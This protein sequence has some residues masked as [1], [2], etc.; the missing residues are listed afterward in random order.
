M[1]YKTF[2]ITALMVLLLSACSGQWNNPH[3]KEADGL[4]VYYTNFQ[5]SPQHL[6]PVVSYSSD[7]NLFIAQIYEPPLGYHFLKRP[8]VLEPLVAQT[9]PEIRFLDKNFRPVKKES[10]DVRY[11]EYTIR[12][13]Q[14]I[15]YQPHP[16]FVMRNGQYRYFFNEEE[17]GKYYRTV[18]DFD[19]VA[20]RELNADDFIYQIKRMADPAVHSPMMGFMSKYIVGMG[21]MTEQL[22]TADREGWLDLRDFTMKGLNKIDEYTYSITINGIYPQFS[23]WLAMAFFAPVPWEADRFFNNPGF[24]EKNLTLDWYPVGTGPFM[25]TENDPN[26]AIILERNPNY[27]LDLYPSEG[28]QEDVA[29][30]YLKDAGK[31]VPFIDKAIFSLDKSTLPMWTKFLQGYYDRSGENHGNVTQNFDQALAIGP[32]GIE[33]SSEMQE[34]AITLS[35]DIKPAIYFYGFNMQ[36]PVVGG[37]SEKQ[38]KLRQAIAIVWDMEAFIDIFINGSALAYTGP[39]APGINGY[40]EGKQGIN[41]YT[42]DWVNG[43]PL[44]KSIAYAQQLMKEAGYPGGRDEK[45]GKPLKLYFDVQSQASGRTSQEWQKRQLKKLGIELEYRSSD[46]NRYK[47]KLRDGNFQL[48]TSGWL[49]DYPD[50][51]NFLFLLIGEEAPLLGNPN[52]ANAANY[53]NPEYNRLF[54]QM[55]TMDNSPERDRIIEKMVDIVRRDSPWFTGY[56]PRE[57]FLNN[58]WVYNGKRHGIS[59]GTLKYLRIDDSLRHQKQAEW[60]RPIVLPLVIIMLVFLMFC[61]PAI[62]AYRRRQKMTINMKN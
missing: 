18:A 24:K 49:A 36:D 42:H 37:Y 22:R 47:E 56:Y 17:E 31:S 32:N 1:N 2:G 44:R 11:S 41:P 35:E 13:K 8:Y 3:K 43:E 6:D 19:Q 34:R 51:E 28:S 5:I 25:M 16:A 33:L 15:R 38:R 50:P 62:I 60:N 29:L 10:S 57:Y 7:E 61:V 53:N 40:Q 12:L 4:S 52:G 48:F 14:G 54:H 45:T 58:Q 27:R 21:S 30:G 46:W 23:Y 59:K 26:R 39:L 55:K 9:M 20:S